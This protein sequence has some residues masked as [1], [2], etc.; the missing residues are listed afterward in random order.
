MKRLYSAFAVAIILVSGCQKERFTTESEW[1]S[2]LLKARLGL[3]DL[4]SDTLLKTNNANALD[5]VYEYK[6]DLGGVSD[7][8]EIPDKTEIIEVGL[9]ELVLDDRT[10]TDTLTLLE[11]Y[12]QSLLLNGRTTDLPAQDVTT[13]E[14]TVI[15]VTEQFFTTATFIEGFIDIEINNDLPVEAELIEFELLNNSDKSVILNGVITN[16]LPYSTDKS[17]YSLAGKTVN[18][19]LEL[20]VKR[21]KT[22][23]SA[24]PVLIDVTK[25]LRTTFVVRDLK[26][27]KATAIFPAQNLIEREEETKYDFGGAELTRLI[28]KEGDVLMKVE[29]SIEES[30]ILE[31]AV[32]NSSKQGVSIKKTWTIPAAEPGKKMQFE[33]RFPIDGFDIILKGKDL[34]AEPSFNHIYNTLVARIAYSGV[35]RTL[36]LQDKI[37]I[38]FGLVDVKPYLLIGD[39]GIHS[40]DVKD[41]FDFKMIKN[42]KGNISLEDATLE[43]EIENSF[44]IQMLV[45]KLEILG[46]NTN[47][48]NIVKLTSSELTRPILLDRAVNGVTFEPTYEKRVMDKSNSNLKLFLEN[49]PNRLVPSIKAKVRPYGTVDQSDF[50]FDFSTLKAGLKLNVPLKF[51][52]DNLTL[53]HNA[54]NDLFDNTNLDQIKEGILKIIATNGFPI[55]GQVEVEFLDNNDVVMDSL[56]F[57]VKNQILAADVDPNSG[58]VSTPQE[59]EL[60]ATI[61]RSKMAT[62]K[63]APKLRITVVFDTKDAMRYAMYSDYFVDVKLI[64][65]FIYE[66]RL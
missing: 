1:L 2:P 24:G 6:Y 14:G 36:S 26:P 51:S 7:I 11:I 20:R 12:P 18:G 62:L 13:N 61:S 16:L 37:K 65:Q 54:D 35:E 9:S 46:E 29:S 50:A 42:V 64:S 17:T 38:E 15:D 25:G 48:P 63:N 39:P 22:K 57:G 53:V 66:G 23:A 31:Y 58:K 43:M 47:R 33:E 59:S 34:Y 60:E 21:I 3:T 28:V 32:P 5:L 44:G 45:E 27:D 55:S 40:F 4:V 19:V 56:F 41:T 30:I 49:T 10:F 52:L 8:L